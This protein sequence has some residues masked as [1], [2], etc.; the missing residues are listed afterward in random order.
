MSIKKVTTMHT[1]LHTRTSIAM[2]TS[3]GIRTS[4]TTTSMSTA[5][6]TGMEMAV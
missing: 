3:R 5:T 1:G 6:S 2:T 4:I